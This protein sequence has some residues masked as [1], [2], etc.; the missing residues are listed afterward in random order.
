MNDRIEIAAVKLGWEPPV[1]RRM[2][3]SDAQHNNAHPTNDL[4][5]NNGL[6]SCEPSGSFC[7][8]S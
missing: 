7:S 6:G 4:L 3:A 8:T 1:L 2:D 5:A